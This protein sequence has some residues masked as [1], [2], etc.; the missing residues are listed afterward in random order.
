MLCLPLYFLHSTFERRQYNK[1]FGKFIQLHFKDQVDKP[2]YIEFNEENFRVVDNEDV[3]YM[4]K[5][6][7]E[8]SETPDLFIIQLESGT[9]VLLPKNKFTAETGMLK[10]KL[11]SLARMHNFSFHSDL[12][13]KW[14]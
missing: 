9:A 10:E 13:W 6:I 12:D 5:D 3:N 1:H 11:S 4:Y 8:A 14:K 2:S 7:V